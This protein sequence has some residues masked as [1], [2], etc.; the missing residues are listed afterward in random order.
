MRNIHSILLLFLVVIACVKDPLYQAPEQIA[1]L[2]PENETYADT[3]NAKGDTFTNTCLTAA[4]WY[5][6]SICSHPWVNEADY[7]HKMAKWTIHK[8][9][10]HTYFSFSGLSRV[11]GTMLSGQDNNQ[12][13][14]CCLES[15]KFM[16]NTQ[17]RGG[18]DT[19]SFVISV[20]GKD[21]F[22]LCSSHMSMIFSYNEPVD[23]SR[24]VVLDTTDQMGDPDFLWPFESEDDDQ[25]EED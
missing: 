18:S 15:S 3:T 19:S 14:R 4:L 8:N 16:V 24:I 20:I 6:L 22:I 25:S 2:E 5:N 7:D 12:S 10:A 9:A 21:F 23:T 17:E 13:W 11:S 1:E